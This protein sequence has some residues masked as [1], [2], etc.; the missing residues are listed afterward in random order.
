MYVTAI[1]DQNSECGCVIQCP[2]HPLVPFL[3]DSVYSVSVPTVYSSMQLNR[4]LDLTCGDT[5]FAAQGGRFV[6]LF[7]YLFI[8]VIEIS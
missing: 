2:N 3:L 5:N 8:Q 7:I 1:N 6:I 4:K